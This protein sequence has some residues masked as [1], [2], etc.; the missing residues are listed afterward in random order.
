MTSYPIVLTRTG[1]AVVIGG[2]DVAWRKVEGL[3][4]AGVAVRVVAPELV[5]GLEDL[6]AA[7]R[8]EAVRRRY[9]VGD[10]AAAGLVIAATD[11]RSVNEAAAREATRRGLLLNVVDDPV[12]STFHAPAVVRRGP[13]C[14]AISTGGSSPSLAARLRRDLE[15]SI[16][17]EYGALARI[18]GE[19]RGWVLKAVPV[20]ARESLWDRLIDAMLPLLKQGR[21]GEARRAGM[22]LAKAAAGAA[23]PEEWLTGSSVG[24]KEAAGE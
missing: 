9:R 1:P 2:G 16:G 22:N 12:H 24:G 23:P 10:L 20:Q 14:V 6:A 19:W 4:S 11:D 21:E 7:E 5:Q 18:L 15:A 13:V 8:I 17:P 3:L